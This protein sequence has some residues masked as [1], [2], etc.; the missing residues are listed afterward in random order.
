[1]PAHIFGEMPIDQILTGPH[2]VRPVGN[3]AFKVDNYV[4]GQY[5]ELVANDEFYKGRPLLDRFIIRFG[6]SDAMSAALE[7]REIDG[8]SISPG[9]VFDR[10]ASQDYLIGNTVP[11][12]LPYGFAINRERWPDHG[13]GLN[14][15]IMHAIDVETVNEQLMSGSSRPSNYLF[16]HIFGM[17]QPPEGFPVYDYDVEKAAAILEEIGWD[18]NEELEWIMWGSPSPTEDALQAMLASAGIRTKYN[19]ID[20]ATVVDQLYVEGNFD[21]VFADFGGA[22]SMEDNWDYIGCHLTFDGGGYNYARYCNE[23]VDALWQQGLESA[24]TAERKA[25]FD[26]VTMLLAEDPPQATLWRNAACYVWNRRVQGAYPY[27]YQLPF[28]PP[29]ERIWVSEA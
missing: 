9:E 23:E 20:V 5:I 11:T 10:L 28:R 26:D 25:I 4:E 19:V 12:S 22:Q 6:D 8:F 29:F 21:I 15:A 18:S 7:A 13:A 3:G 2:A 24:D 17:E 14:K 16:E 1:M 27:Q